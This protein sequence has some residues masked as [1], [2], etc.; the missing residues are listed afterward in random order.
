M[1]VRTTIAIAHQ[2]QKEIE[3]NSYQT[4]SS[5]FTEINGNYHLLPSVPSTSESRSVID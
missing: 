3:A 2:G 1:Q 4:M 5:E